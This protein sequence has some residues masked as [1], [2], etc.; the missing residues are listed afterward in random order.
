MKLKQKLNSL[1][2]P[3]FMVA[4]TPRPIGAKTKVFT[5]TT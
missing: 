1:P 5:N 3:C 2:L 4:E